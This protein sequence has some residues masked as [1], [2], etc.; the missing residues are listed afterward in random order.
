MEI[1][2]RIEISEQQSS[3]SD[4]RSEELPNRLRVVETNPQTDPRWESFVAS[5]PDGSVYH[6]P[7]WLAVL[8]REYKQQ[9]VYLACEDRNGKFLA[10]LPM[11]YTRG[12]PFGLGGPLSGRRLTSLPRTPLAG[13]LSVDL[14]ASV[15]LMRAAIQKIANDPGIC[16][17]IKMQDRSLDGIADGL[18][19]LPWRLSYQLRLPAP[20]TGPFRIKDSH[21]RNSIKW[22]IN[23]ATRLGVRV[24]AA[25]TE[26]DLRAWYSLYLDTMRR[27][28][29]PARPYRFFAAMWELLHA[30][31]M[32]QLLLAEKHEAGQAT[33]IG[34]SIFLKYNKTVSYV[35][36]GASSTDFSL[37]PNDMIQWEAINQACRQGFELFDFGEVPEGNTALA[38]FKKKWG[39]EP[40]RLYRY[41]S[42]VAQPMQ[43]AKAD[44]ESTAHK[45]AKAAWNRLPLGLTA[46]LGDRAFYYL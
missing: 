14:N 42:S 31:G 5:H 7:A 38:K 32:M 30:C 39:P 27:N 40:I 10:I 12:L 9:G 24:R 2:E 15:P 45:I 34:G 33:M 19:A 43:T 26:G 11:L 8:E 20:S 18:T 17:Q 21:D 23:K 35:F 1:C 22:A 44:A 37:R 25:E 46:W 3:L 6:H 41:Y 4:L 13:P 29:V 16:L 28:M 36:N